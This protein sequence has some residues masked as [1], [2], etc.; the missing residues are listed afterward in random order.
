MDISNTLARVASRVLLSCIAIVI[1]TCMNYNLVE[2]DV[3]GRSPLKF[4]RDLRVGLMMSVL[5]VATCKVVKRLSWLL[6]CSSIWIFTLV[7]MHPV[8]C[9][10][11]SYLDCMWLMYQ[12]VNILPCTSFTQRRAPKW[13]YVYVIEYD[14][15]HLLYRD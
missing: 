13:V 1:N 11:L 2:S 14:N 15:N 5:T 7:C 9:T 3:D 8:S 12:L 4:L 10:L 6:E